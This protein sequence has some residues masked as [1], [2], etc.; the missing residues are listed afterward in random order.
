MFMFYGFSSK[1][2]SQQNLIGPWS[3]VI[4][5][6]LKLEEQHKQT[7]QTERKKKQTKTKAKFN[8]QNMEQSN[9]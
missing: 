7:K 2:P 9:M 4:I 6:K 1:I 5:P 8:P 3:K